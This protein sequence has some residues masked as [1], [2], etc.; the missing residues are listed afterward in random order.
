ML[1]EARRQVGSSKASLA[2]FNSRTASLADFCA[3]C[4]KRHE[5]L[6]ECLAFYAALGHRKRR[7]KRTIKEQASEER[8]YKQLECIEKRSGQRQLVLAY[9]SWG[10][11]AG[12]PGAACNRGN[13]P[14]IGVGLM[15]KLAR[16]F[17]VAPT[18]EAY[19]QDMLSVSWAMWALG[20]EG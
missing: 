12:R 7:W 18:P 2:G 15:R 19:V 17:V 13:L 16:R 1:G 10:M 4:G 14:C 11:V 3:Y 9:G 8:V 6:D 5:T 20:R